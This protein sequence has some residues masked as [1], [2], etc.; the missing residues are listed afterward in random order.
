MS[1]SVIRVFVYLLHVLYT[2]PSSLSCRVSGIYRYP[3]QLN[4]E[5]SRIGY[6]IL[7]T[8]R[9]FDFKLASALVIMPHGICYFKTGRVVITST[10]LI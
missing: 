7:E 6:R 2:L 5:D 3:R 4:G 10:L 9:C 1:T 8:E